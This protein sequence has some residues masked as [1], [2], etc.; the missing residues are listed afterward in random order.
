MGK[1]S[2]RI[3]VHDKAMG[4]NI[5]THI[6]TRQGMHVYIYVVFACLF[7]KAGRS[8]SMSRVASSA[9]AKELKIMKKIPQ[10]AE[11]SAVLVGESWLPYFWNSTRVSI[12]WADVFWRVEFIPWS[13][14]ICKIVIA[15]V[16][17]YVLPYNGRLKGKNV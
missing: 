7:L 8:A 15:R 5:N 1:R 17:E 11:A 4:I 2:L 10:D 6:S 12:M 14:S 3:I 16:T 13:L 9:A